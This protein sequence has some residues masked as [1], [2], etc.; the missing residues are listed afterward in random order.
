MQLLAA[1]LQ[2]FV[3]NAHGKKVRARS[4]SKIHTMDAKTT[5][6]NNNVHLSVTRSVMYHFG[7]RYFK[8][9]PRRGASAAGITK[10]AAIRVAAPPTIE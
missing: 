8:L 9:C 1:R 3:I 4:R 5:I 2:L 7:A 6:I 10:F